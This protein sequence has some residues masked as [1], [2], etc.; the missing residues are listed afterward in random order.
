MMV[1]SKRDD[2]VLYGFGYDFFL[3]WY[4]IDVVAIFQ[5]RFIQQYFYKKHFPVIY[6]YDRYNDAKRNSKDTVPQ[7]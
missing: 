7:N 5:L 3:L 2:S 6:N 4:S 1:V